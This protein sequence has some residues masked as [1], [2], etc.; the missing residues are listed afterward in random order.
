MLKL[1]KI[2][3]EVPYLLFKSLFQKAKKYS[4]PLIDVI[5]I[6]SYDKNL[7]EV[8][9]RFVNLKYIINDEWVF[10]SNYQSDKAKQFKDN[11]NIAATMYWKSIDVQI[12]IKAKI[13]KSSKSLSDMHFNGREKGKNA[14]A[15]SSSQSRPITSYEEVKKNYANTLNNEIILTRPN[16][17]GGYS[18]FPYSFE[19][20]TGHHSRVNKRELFELKSNKW[21]KSI[22]QP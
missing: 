16:Y 2:S 11:N 1:Q 22:L 5:A 7:N 4:D 6:S 9:T 18:F 15:I 13:F 10:F 14:L 12:R 21:K 17:W 19:F 3:Q 8:N 20:W